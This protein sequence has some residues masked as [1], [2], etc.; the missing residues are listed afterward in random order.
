MIYRIAADVTVLF[1]LL[2]IV[3]VV[4]GGLLAFYW[5]PV[6]WIHLP[7]LA[8]GTWN[9]FVGV[10]CPL[11]PLEN[12]FRVRGGKA[13]YT[14]SFIDHYLLAFVEPERNNELVQWALG[15]VLVAANLGL[16]SVLFIQR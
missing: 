6:I 2:F 11:T 9:Q 16:Y 1:H 3:F 8:W 7:P 15:A 10:K 12:Y 14:T 13:G 4:A 5:N